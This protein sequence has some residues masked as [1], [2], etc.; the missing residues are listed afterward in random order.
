MPEPTAAP[1]P[2]GP[3]L[4]KITVLSMSPAPGSALVKNAKPTFTANVRYNVGTDNRWGEIDLC[5]D[6]PESGEKD[7][8]HP[9][10]TVRVGTGVGTAT[11]SNNVE[12]PDNR[13]DFTIFVRL[14]VQPPD[15]NRLRTHDV[16]I[17][18]ATR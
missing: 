2:E 7:F 11:I 8:C 14:W 17:P 15:Q 3:P 18:Y 10:E 5:R 13:N 12:V 4:N 6:P 1:A 9:F 16:A